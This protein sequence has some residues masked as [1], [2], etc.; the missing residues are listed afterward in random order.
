MSHGTKA[1]HKPSVD[2]FNIHGLSNYVKVIVVF[3][4]RLKRAGLAP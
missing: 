2:R 1:T 4:C 3:G